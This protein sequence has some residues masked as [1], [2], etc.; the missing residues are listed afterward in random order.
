[1]C[2][3]LLIS[4]SAISHHE[5]DTVWAPGWSIFVLLLRLFICLSLS[6]YQLAVFF[7]RYC[8]W[9]QTSYLSTSRRPPKPLLTSSCTTASSRPHGTGSSS[10]SPSTRPSWCPTTSP[11]RRSRTTWHGWWWTA[12]WTS[13]SWWTSF[14][15][16]T[17][18][19]SDPPGRSS[20][21]PSWSGWTTWR[22]G[23]LLTC[24]PACR[25]TSSTP[26]R[27]SMRWVQ[28]FCVCAGT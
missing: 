2:A 12:S 26:L 9:A 20:Q 4:R 24:C 25:T 8:S 6:F 7:V 21:T 11:S 13:S 15:T 28:W 10:S 1:M 18:R 19:S 3:A 22:R 17:P 5:D 14:W 27:M 16:S 23:L